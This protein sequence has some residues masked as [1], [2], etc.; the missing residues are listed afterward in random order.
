MGPLAPYSSQLTHYKKGALLEL[1][2][3]ASVATDGRKHPMDKKK[4]IGVDVHQARTVRANRFR[5]SRGASVEEGSRGGV[6][7][8]GD[9]RP[10]QRGKRTC[11]L[12]ETS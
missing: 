5:L 11:Q 3:E 8:V 10:P 7:V 12:R 9:D 1:R 4:N 6:A 2:L